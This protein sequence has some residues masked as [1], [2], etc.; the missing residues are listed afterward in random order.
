MD[1]SEIIRKIED[2]AP[3]ELAESWDCSGWLVETQNHDIKRVMLCLTVTE[4]IINQAREKNCDMIISH[5][6]LFSVPLTWKDIDIYCAHTNLDL[7]EGGTT[8]TLIK[9]IFPSHYPAPLGATH[10]DISG[11]FSSPCPSP[12]ESDTHVG[13]SGE[14]PSHIPSPL[15]GEGRISSRGTSDR[16]SGEGS[17]IK[18]CQLFARKIQKE[19]Q[20]FLRYVNC[21]ISVDD[22]AQKLSKISPNLR[23][24]NNNNV[25]QIRKI[26]FC[27]GSG[28]EFIQEAFEN[29]ADAIVTGDV[30]FHTA[31]ES[32]VVLF[33]VGHFESEI[34]ILEVF[35]QII[36]NRIEIIKAEEKSPF[37]YIKKY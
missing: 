26:A 23:Y 2:F 11:E 18:D 19:T 22:F 12:L 30:K 35:E 28:S 25:M 33:D 15:V 5:H 16:N 17:E 8:D 13:V 14:F 9:A 3:L 29:S 6:P 4:D 37:K 10:V 21:E 31:V 32:P 34:L 7:A 27:A 36:G 20:G 24:V 1:K